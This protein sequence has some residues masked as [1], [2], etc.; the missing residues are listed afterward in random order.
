MSG[1]SATFDAALAFAACAH[2]DQ[3][4]KGTGAPGVPYIVHPMHVATILLRHGFDEPMIV[5]ALL[6]DVV[7]D[8]GVPLDDIRDR[9]G[10]AVAEMV[11]AVSELK[12]D[13]GGARRPWR[14]RKEEQLEQLAQA[15][16]RVAALKC[17]DALHNASCTV[18]ELERDGGVVWTRFNA[19]PSDTV[20]YYGEIARLCGARLGDAH[21]LVTELRETV[22]W[23]ARR[24]A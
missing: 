17:A 19:G 3:V 5:A 15:D 18:V 24:T 16:A 4:R 2:R 21:P 20:W 12:T 22:A 11:A 7:E 13:D 6:H 9:F 8:C 23:L 10:E 14:V 1:F